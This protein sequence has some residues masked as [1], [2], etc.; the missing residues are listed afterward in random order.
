MNRNDRLIIPYINGFCNI[1]YRKFFE[2]YYERIAFLYVNWTFLDNHGF[3]VVVKDYSRSFWYFDHTVNE[4][5]FI[6]RTLSH[7]WMEKECSPDHQHSKQHN[8]MKESF[9][10]IRPHFPLVVRSNAITRTR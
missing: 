3:R 4:A 8:H 2:V 7:R 5:N 9:H 1:A 10:R 6:V